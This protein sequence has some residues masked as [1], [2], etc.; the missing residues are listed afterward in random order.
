MVDYATRYPEAV[1]LTNIHA[2]TVVEALLRIFARVGF[3]QEIISDQGTQFTVDLTQQLWKLC[4]IKPIH[5]STYHPQTNGL[6]K[7]FNGMLK[8]LLQTCATSHRD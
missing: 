7:W 5:S 6:C 4:G 2:E 1:P 3:R 8:Q